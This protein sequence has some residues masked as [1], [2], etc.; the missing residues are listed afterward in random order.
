MSEA[1][2]GTTLTSP[3]ISRSLS[4]AAHSRDP[5]AHP[6][7]L[8]CS[9]GSGR[10]RRLFR[11]RRFHGPHVEIEQAFALVALFL[12]LLPQLDDLLED[13]HVEPLALGLR[14]DLL[15]LLAQFM[16][17]GVQILDPLNERTNPPAGNGDVRHG[18]SLLNEVV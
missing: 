14:K 9:I 6:G 12:V 2:S 10:L 5:L 7:A 18:A 13:L 4:S 3:R 15:L 16:H 17:F 1:T 8:A 11:R